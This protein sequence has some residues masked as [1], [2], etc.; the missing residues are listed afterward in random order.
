MEL[1]TPVTQRTIKLALGDAIP[2]I[3]CHGVSWPTLIDRNLSKVS[4]VLG[5]SLADHDL[6]CPGRLA[7]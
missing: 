4:A 7:A 5:A 1:T 2:R 3:G 6:A